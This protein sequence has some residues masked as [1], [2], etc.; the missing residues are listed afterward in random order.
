MIGKPGKHAAR[1]RPWLAYAA[2]N[3]TNNI[4][5]SGR[6]ILADIAGYFTGVVV[7]T[8]CV[9]SIMILTDG[10]LTAEAAYGCTFVASVAG[11]AAGDLASNNGY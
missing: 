11:A 8:L 6:G 4:D 9:G 1:D 10:I 7:E 2:D 3:P 5:P